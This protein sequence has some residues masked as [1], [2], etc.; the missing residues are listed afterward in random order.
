M[1]KKLVKTAVYSFIFGLM[2]GLLYYKNINSFSAGLDTVSQ[3]A[4]L[5]QY[6]LQVLRFA[7]K[8]TFA[9]VASV[10]I[11]EAARITAVDS[12]EYLLGFLKSFA[13]LFML[14]LIGF[15]VLTVIF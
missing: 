9:T 2:L 13:V 5:Q 3:D 4:P 15:A 1:E 6:I 12:Y 7:V 8:M 11:M 10:W 14:V